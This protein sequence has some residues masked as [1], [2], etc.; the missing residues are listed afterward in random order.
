MIDVKAVLQQGRFYAFDVE[1]DGNKDQRPV[2][3]SFCLFDNGK[4]VEERYFLLNPGR[5]ISRYASAVHGIIDTDVKDRPRFED[6]EEEIRSLITGTTLVGHDCLQ[7][8]QIIS[9]H[10]PEA[11]ILPAA[12]IDTY[13]LAKTLEEQK[14]TGVS[15]KLGEIAARMGVSEADAPTTLKRVRKHAS[16]FDAWMTGIVANRF[17]SLIH[18]GWRARQDASQRF[19]NHLPLKLRLELQA[20]LDERENRCCTPTL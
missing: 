2:E 19:T 11:A 17:A 18:D 20:I 8:L 1:G 13:R 16:S 4:F 7:D 6:V 14:K 5:S 10:L 3:I 12:I 9:R 15:L